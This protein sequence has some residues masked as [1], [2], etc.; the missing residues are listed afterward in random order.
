MKT[1]AILVVV[2]AITIFYVCGS[3]FAGYLYGIGSDN[4]YKIDASDGSYSVIDDVT[5]PVSGLAYVPEPATLLLL[6]LG[7][8]LIRRKRNG[9]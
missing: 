7:G 3:S 6:G 8:L 1:K 2:M 5:V 4:L 9:S